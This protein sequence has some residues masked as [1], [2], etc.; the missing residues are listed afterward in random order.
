MI[1]ATAIDQDRYLS[2][3]QIYL[4]VSAESNQA[5]VLRKTPQ[6]VKISSHDGVERLIRQALPGLGL[7]YVPNPP[8]AVPIKSS[9]HYFLLQRSGPEW[10]AVVRARNLAAYV[11]AEVPEP[12]LELVVLLPP[13]S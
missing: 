9:H 10:D 4:A 11:P 8:S 12:Q 1:H 7:T 13:K 5:D 3:P 2:A 6:L